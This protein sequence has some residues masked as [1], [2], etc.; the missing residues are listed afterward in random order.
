MLTQWARQAYEENVMKAVGEAAIL[1]TP[2]RMY[3][4]RLDVA[5]RLLYE[6]GAYETKPLRI[7]DVGCGFGRLYDAI[8]AYPDVC[9]GKYH[10]IEA[11]AGVVHKARERLFDTKQVRIELGL[12]PA[13]KP[14]EKY[15]I[16]AAL[17][18]LPTVPAYEI[19]WFLQ[20]F[21]SAATFKALSWIDPDI[22]AIDMPNSKFRP[23]AFSEVMRIMGPTIHLHGPTW[24]APKQGM[25]GD[26]LD[27]Y[28]TG[29][30]VS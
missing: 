1:C 7:L 11:V 19:E 27:P 8:R 6:S 30:W 24:L 4:H 17:G 23:T 18:V 26:G 28:W 14:D 12:F 2:E 3:W 13:A 29:V 5:T 16:A 25:D 22:H 21:K 9:V 10:G 15:S 20:E